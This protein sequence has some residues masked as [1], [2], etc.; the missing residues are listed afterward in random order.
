MHSCPLCQR[1][2]SALNK[3]LKNMHLIHN[4][5]ERRL[6]LNMASGRVN[7]RAAPCPVPGCQNQLSRLDRH[8]NQSHAELTIAERAAKMNQAKRIRTMELLAELRA[9]DSTPAM[10]SM[11]DVNPSPLEEEID[12]AP[13]SPVADC[14]SAECRRIRLGYE[15]ELEGVKA[16]RDEF[17]AEVRLL[18]TKLQKQLRSMKSGRTTAVESQE[19]ERV[20]EGGRSSAASEK[21]GRSS[22]A[23]E[24]AGPSS[25][26]SEEEAGSSSFSPWSSGSGRG[27]LMRQISLPPS[28]ED[29]L[30]TYRAHHE[31][32]DPTPK[33]TENAISKV[34]R[35]KLSSCIWP[36][37]AAGCPTG[38]FW[39]TCP[40]SAAGPEVWW[41]AG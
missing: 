32:L 9:T 30:R 24:K 36:T 15:R 35:V 27:N 20:T 1:Y 25:A 23:S 34:S 22:A 18:R 40:G 19:D 29:Y 37:T 41:R 8:I 6:L 26:A 13:P 3:H 33:M 4:A 7:I 28:M 31:G 2:F 10:Q 5:E 11:L 12:V 14:G 39:I 21:A 16:E 17:C 38:F